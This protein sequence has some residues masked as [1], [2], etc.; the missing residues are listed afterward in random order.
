MQLPKPC[1]VIIMHINWYPGHME[2]ARRMVLEHMKM[3]DVVIELLDARIPSASA[4]P[5]IDQLAGSKPRVIALNKADTAEQGQSKL[6]VEYFRM[7]GLMAVQLDSVSGNG[8]K[9]L[10]RQ[11]ESAAAPRLKAWA[12]KGIRSRAA[13]VMIL[14]IPNVGKSS[15]INRLLGKNVTRTGD[16]PGVTRGKQW[17]KIGASLELLDTPG[18]LWPKLEDQEAAFRLAATGAIADDIYDLEDVARRLLIL[19]ADAY[20]ER[21][22]ERYGLETLPDNIDELLSMIGA[23]RGC[24]LGGGIIDLVKTRRMILTEFRNGKLGKFTLDRV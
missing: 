13:R 20:P 7:A 23:K 17:V 6:W 11:V 2:K 1:M 15:L 22:C 19:L 9:E 14:G 8:T 12:A 24:L 3:V 5:V 10:V 16:K 4:N 18:M 21:L